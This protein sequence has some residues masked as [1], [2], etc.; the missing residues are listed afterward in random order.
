MIATAA[1]LRM[2]DQRFT[3]FGC[4]GPRRFTNTFGVCVL[5]QRTDVACRWVSVR[6]R[7]EHDDLGPFCPCSVHDSLLK[8][9][10]K[11]IT[12]LRAYVFTIM[13]HRS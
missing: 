2:T 10:K 12:E 13:L 7:L 8:Y 6:R 9:A 3:I 1:I 11:K 4:C 5:P